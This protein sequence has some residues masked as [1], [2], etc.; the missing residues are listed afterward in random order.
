MLCPVWHIL[1][2]VS[3][4]EDAEWA[5]QWWL[6]TNIWSN[7]KKQG[8]FKATLS[9]LSAK[10]TLKEDPSSDPQNNPPWISQQNIP[11]RNS[12]KQ[13]GV[14]Y[15]LLSVSV[16]EY[17]LWLLSH[18]GWLLSSGQCTPSPHV[19][20]ALHSPWPPL[21]ASDSLAWTEYRIY[22][23]ILFLLLVRNNV[24]V[25]LQVSTLFSINYTGHKNICSPCNKLNTCRMKGLGWNKT[26]FNLCMLKS[27]LVRADVLGNVSKIHHLF[28]KRNCS[29]QCR[30]SAL[31]SKRKTGAVKACT[32]AFM[33][34][35]SNSLLKYFILHPSFPSGWIWVENVIFFT[36]RMLK[37]L[38]PWVKAAFLDK[39]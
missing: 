31:V 18:S 32:T 21:P 39:W 24:S 27:C 13:Q 34:H 6:V 35:W 20:T 16:W 30:T 25:I 4:R 33:R 5:F 10:T 26:Y 19:S 14:S 36:A 28:M 37:F 15:H 9:I 11:Q 1:A 2:E 3:S 17:P 22:F 23:V 29:M 7:T 8:I 38:P 12:L